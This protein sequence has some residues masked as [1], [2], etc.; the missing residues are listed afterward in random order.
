M[1]AETEEFE[2]SPSNIVTSRNDFSVEVKMPKTILY[3]ED[4]K[5]LSIFAEPLVTD[6]PT[7]AIRRND[8]R[9]WFTPEGAAVISGDDR[10]RIIGNIRRAFE[11]R[12]W[13]LT[14]E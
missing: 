8:I 3:D 2:H 5:R 1:S 13:T 7:I 14:V 6:E 4:G 9:S 12:S 10:T 11:F